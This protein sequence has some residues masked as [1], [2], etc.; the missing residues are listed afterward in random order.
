M[1]TNVDNEIEA[2]RAVLNALEPLDAAA[3]ESVLDYIFKRLSIQQLAPSTAQSPQPTPRAPIAP[4][5]VPPPPPMQVHIRDFKEEKQPRTAIEMAALVAYYLE[6]L[7]AEDA[8]KDSVGT[9]D[10][11]TYFKIAGFKLPAQQRFTLV[12]ARNAGYFDSVGN[13]QYKLNAVGHN[14][15]V[16]SMPRKGND[17]PAP[18]KRTTKKRVTKKAI[19]KKVANQKKSP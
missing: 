2:I 6:N 14:L 17:G 13:G 19:K 16:H 8:H 10:L 5:V 12:N 1:A 3:R 4:P 15:V 18:R 7:A 9:D 11:D